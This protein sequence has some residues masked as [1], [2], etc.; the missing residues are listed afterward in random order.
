[1]EVVTGVTLIARSR[2]FIELC[3]YVALQ[4]QRAQN[5]DSPAAA[6]HYAWL[7]GCPHCN[8]DFIQFLVGHIAS[9]H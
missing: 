2:T 1:M 3:T 6:H 9:A 4:N 5:V 8:H 7:R